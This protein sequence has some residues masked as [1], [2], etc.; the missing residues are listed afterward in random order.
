[1]KLL[2]LALSVKRR[3][4]GGA[5]APVEEFQQFLHHMPVSYRISVSP[6]EIAMHI[7][8]A[9][10][11]EAASTETETTSIT[12]IV[13]FVDRP[14]FTELHLC[15]PSRIG[16]LHTVSGL[17][18]AN[19]IDVRDARVYT[20]QDTNIELE[21]YRLVH[22]PPHHRGEPMPL[23]EE[24]KRDLD[25][26]IRS[27][28]AEEVTLEQIFERHYVNLNDTW[29]VDDVTVEAAR[30]YS[31]IVV[32]GEEKMGFLHYF[33]GILAKLGLNVEMCKC[34]GLGGQAI[35]RFYVQP[36]ADPKAV[37]ADIMAALDAE[38]F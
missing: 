36:V 5:F 22:Q 23:D 13:Q 21:I 1:M 37:H 10:Q 7:K 18:F 31:E 35:D 25:F 12:G 28:L 27:L 9:T 14:G 29:Q 2:G 6:E 19:G 8:M 30:S 3:R 34:S 32:V 26:D 4:S 33:S 24:L 15:S 16:K 11:A 20:K 38:N 17:F